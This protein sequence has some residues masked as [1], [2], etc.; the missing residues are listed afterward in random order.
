MKTAPEYP[1]S[2][3]ATVALAAYRAEQSVQELADRFGVTVEQV[4]QW[5]EELAAGAARAFTGVVEP[6]PAG[7]TPLDNKE[8]ALTIAENSTQGFAMIDDRGYCIY[9]NRAWLQTT[10]YTAEEIGSMPLHYLVHHHYPDGRPYPMQDCPIDRALPENF[11][12]RA[13][14]DLFFRKDGS[15]FSVMCAASP[16]FENGRAVATVIEIRDI[17]EGKRVV[18][19]ERELI[20]QAISA[21][22]TNAK[23]RTFFEQ[24]SHFAGVMTVDGALIEANRKSLDSTG[25]TR[26]DVIGKKFWE[27]GW[28]DRS[29]ATVETLR[30]ASM[31]A[32]GGQQFQEELNYFTAD[33]A[34]RIVDLV[35]TPVL[36]DAG[37]VLFIAPTGIDITER[38]Q[39]EER[40]RLLDTINQATREAADAKSIMHTV[41]RLL[42]QHLGATRCAYADMEPDNDRFTIRGDWTVSGVASTVGVY[43]LDL[44][45]PR[46][47]KELRS[48]HT[49][50]VRD[51]DAELAP[52]EGAEMFNAIGIKAIV[53]CPLVKEGQLVALMAVHQGIPRKWTKNEVALV[54]EVVE[55]SWAHIERV[56][57]TEALREADRRKTEFLAILAHELR[58]PL[59]P[60]RNGLQIIQQAVDNPAVIARVRD[61]MERQVDQMVHLVN[62]LLDIARITHG[63]IG[64]RKEPVALKE[65]VASAVESNLPLIEASNHE[66][67]VN[68][69]DSL[70][71]INVDPTRI[72]QVLSNF[73]N[74]AAKYTPSGGRIRLLAYQES[75]EIVISITDN[76]IGIPA[77]SLSS[78]FEMFS[79][80]EQKAGRVHGGLGI[81][82]ALVR[83]LVEL[84]GGTVAVN[85]PGPGQ[86]S[87]FKIRLPISADSVLPAS[88]LLPVT[89]ASA[90]PTNPLRVLVVDDNE[91]AAQTTSHLL[92]MLGHSTEVAND[93]LKALQIA[94]AFR[95]DVVFLDIGMPGMDGYQVAR[96]LRRED[97]TK[98]TV[99]VAVT[100][101]GSMDDI[102]HARKAGF[103]H[104][105]TKPVRLST[106]ESLLSKLS[107]KS[108]S[109]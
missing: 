49:L 9:A 57:A 74:N 50:V 30:A 34:E 39:V 2:F 42:G 105:L 68:V 93:G 27:C 82:L 102:V 24:G 47:A 8:L 84:H 92:A 11:D 21:A 73:L 76:G 66:L 58:N 44:F 18:E 3:K 52:R 41:T 77:E 107:G 64:I 29:P 86:G 40:L 98:Q 33:G 15:T 55:R 51:V 56:R 54:E 12:V 61:M 71:L 63:Q 4:E 108:P 22:Q 20:A 91:D 43:S 5:K 13:H 37:Q 59:A 88:S 28:W 96:T 7:R 80:V 99:L 70:P 104:H 38:K 85:S 6:R 78:V 60:V 106:F 109:S 97:E 31:G 90:P 75:R 36:D 53:T 23:F 83:Q 94:R 81:G 87:T 79:R 67:T 10:G 72:A 46:A 65:L 16:I 95:P 1:A 103:D 62:D 32:A 48:G 25:F 89:V 69:P 101:W 35:L 17:T 14:E 45:G 26:E 100:G 19:H